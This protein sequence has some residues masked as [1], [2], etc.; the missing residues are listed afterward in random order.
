MAMVTADVVPWQ[1]GHK[2]EQR[3]PE[4]VQ[5]QKEV[6]GQGS[7]TGGADC[8]QGCDSMQDVMQA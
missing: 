3:L 5:A 8:D 7:A 6:R 4:V 1:V 2:A